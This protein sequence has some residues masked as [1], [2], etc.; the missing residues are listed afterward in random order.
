MTL[1]RLTKLV[2]TSFHP[3]VRSAFTKIDSWKEQLTD[4]AA[5]VVVT[6]V[7]TSVKQ[8]PRSQLGMYLYNCR[9]FR[10]FVMVLFGS[11]HAFVVAS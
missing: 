2:L 10:Q 8:L 7:Y 3:L 9:Y 11:V 1:I 5:A 4:R 6:V